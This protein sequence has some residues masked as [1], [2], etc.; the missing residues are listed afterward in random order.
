MGRTDEWTSK[1]AAIRAMRR[2][3][4]EADGLMRREERARSG[5]AAVGAQNLAVDPAGVGARQERHHA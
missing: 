1:F 5:D 3:S 4:A 2:A